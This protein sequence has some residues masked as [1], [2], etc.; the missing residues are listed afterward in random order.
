MATK[1]ASLYRK[2]QGYG[3]PEGHVPLANGSGGILYCL[4][5]K[6][7]SGNKLRYRLH[8]LKVMKDSPSGMLIFTGASNMKLIELKY[9]RKFNKKLNF[10]ASTYKISKN[11]P[12][13]LK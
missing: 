1:N 9:H 6:I 12:C 8:P 11:K 4:V 2:I 10:N 5:L 13:D 3:K 7:Q